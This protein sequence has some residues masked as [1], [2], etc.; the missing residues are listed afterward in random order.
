MAT[1]SE[2]GLEDDSIRN[3]WV[4]KHDKDTPTVLVITVHNEGKKM[5]VRITPN[6]VLD[7]IDSGAVVRIDSK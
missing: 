7:M 5:S 4:L 2:I 6:D 3:T 1:F